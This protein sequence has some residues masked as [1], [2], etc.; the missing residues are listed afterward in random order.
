MSTQF[1]PYHRPTLLVVDD[2][3]LTAKMLV[4]TAKADGYRAMCCTE[5]ASVDHVL[6]EEL[7]PVIILTDI[8]LRAHESGAAAAKR[9]KTN[10]PE[11]RIVFMSGHHPDMID[12]LDVSDPLV[13]F[14]QKPFI[15][16]DV[17]QILDPERPEVAP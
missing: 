17:V 7:G 3:P 11:V 12:D 15:F 5:P 2:D 6:E 10:H 4:L 16:R 8:D 9:W 13:G 14:I 1:T